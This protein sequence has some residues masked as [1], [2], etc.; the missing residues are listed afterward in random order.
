M[1]GPHEARFIDTATAPG[2]RLRVVIPVLDD[3]EF[4]Y[5]EPDGVKWSPRPGP[6]YPTAGDWALV[7]ESSEG[8]W[9]VLLWTPSS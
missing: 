9:C 3:G 5:G 8:T 6:V 7:V 2:D 1:G 4:A